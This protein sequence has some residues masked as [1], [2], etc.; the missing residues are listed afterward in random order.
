MDEVRGSL[1]VYFEG[2]FWVGVFERETDEK[3]SAAKVTFGS[4]PKD[5]EVYE[6]ILK[7]Y[8]G[9]QFSQSVDHSAKELSRNPKRRRREIQKRLSRR[10]VGTKS[11]Q[12]L[13]MQ[14]EADKLERKTLSRELK[15]AEKQRR[16]ELKQQKRKEKR[17]GG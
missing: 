17:R 11:Q 5:V 9:L 12:A 7:N 3:L 6:F 2:Q 10:G 1:T 15:R 14:R 16:F 8:G 13:K 4:E